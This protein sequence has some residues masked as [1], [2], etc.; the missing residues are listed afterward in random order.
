M[1][2]DELLLMLKDGT[3][4]RLL[5]WLRKTKCLNGLARRAGM[6]VAELLA[7]LTSMGTDEARREFIEGIRRCVRS[8]RGREHVREVSQPEEDSNDRKTVGDNPK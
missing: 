5:E 4:D 8:R 7:R 1:T 6:P 3:V 2:T